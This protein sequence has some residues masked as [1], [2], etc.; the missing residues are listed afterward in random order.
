MKRAMYICF[1]DEKGEEMMHLLRKDVN[2]FNN[3]NSHTNFS[4]Q[5]LGSLQLLSPD[6]N[7]SHTVAALPFVVF[8]HMLHYLDRPSLAALRCTSRSLHGCVPDVED[9][10]VR[11]RL[12]TSILE[13]RFRHQISTA[14]G[15]DLES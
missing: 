2:D 6:I 13:S 5:A 3:Y 12:S 1:G 9:A 15:I 4:R 14:P 7:L 10:S 8:R 11:Y